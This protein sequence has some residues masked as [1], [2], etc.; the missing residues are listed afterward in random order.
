V[1]Y[2]IRC[3][4]WLPVDR[5]L[6]HVVGRLAVVVRPLVLPQ[7]RP[8]QLQTTV[9]RNLRQRPLLYV[10]D[11]VHVALSHILHQLR[12]SIVQLVLITC[13]SNSITAEQLLEH[14]LPFLGGR[15]N[16]RQVMT[17]VVFA[18]LHAEQVL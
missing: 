6:Q 1:V 16:G 2:E 5:H 14:M 7:L 13:F 9:A 18:V 3:T 17:H 4:P 8:L 11:C 15:A 10:V 12:N